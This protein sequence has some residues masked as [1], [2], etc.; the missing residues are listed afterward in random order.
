MPMFIITGSRIIAPTSPACSSSVRSRNSGSLNGT[1]STSSEA[2]AGIPR[3][4]GAFHGR[5]AGPLASIDGVTE[6]ITASW[7]PW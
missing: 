6:N 3:E 7:W 4:N 5:S 2:C 1:I